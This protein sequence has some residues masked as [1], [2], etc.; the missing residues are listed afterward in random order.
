M[1]K[2]E[3]MGGNKIDC[4]SNFPM[5]FL[6]HHKVDFH[7]K[8]LHETSLKRQTKVMLCTI[9]RTD[10]GLGLTDGSKR[11]LVKCMKNKYNNG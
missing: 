11:G 7:N 10:D 4:S 6:F 9:T 1:N 2:A 5:Q 3:K 8:Q